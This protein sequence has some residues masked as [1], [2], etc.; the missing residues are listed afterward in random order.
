MLNLRSLIAART[1][2][3]YVTST[4]G[5]TLLPFGR[6]VLLGRPRPA[7]PFAYARYTF[8]VTLPPFILSIQSKP[9]D[10]IFIGALKF[11]SVIADLLESYN[12]KQVAVG[13]EERPRVEA[14]IW[15]TH[16]TRLTDAGLKQ[17]ADMG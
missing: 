17:I 7:A 6:Y 2:A 9:A 15:Q 5:M 12:S 16:S 11:Y 1:V 13:W 8:L 3:G 14:T 4:F 10:C